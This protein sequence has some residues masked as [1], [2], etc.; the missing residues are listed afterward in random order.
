MQSLSIFIVESQ[1]AKRRLLKIFDLLD[2]CRSQ[3]EPNG[4]A[5]ACGDQPVSRA[6]R[7]ERYQSRTGAPRMNGLPSLALAEDPAT[8]E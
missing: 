2:A 6:G 4:V 7:P 1:T 3:L 8:H 5:Y